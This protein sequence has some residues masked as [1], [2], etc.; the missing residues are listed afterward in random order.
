MTRGVA[1]RSEGSPRSRPGRVVLPTALLIMIIPC[2][3]ARAQVAGS[4][5]PTVN[6]PSGVVSTVP[7]ESGPRERVVAASVARAFF[8]QSLNCLGIAVRASA[9]V[10]DRALTL[11]CDKIR[12]MLKNIPRVRETLVRRGTELHIIGQHE[13]TSD[14]P[15]FRNQQD[16]VFVDNTGRLALIDERARGLGGHFPSCGE[17]NILRLPDDRYRGHEICIHEFAHA[18]MDYGMTA[19]ERK[20]I[21]DQYTESISIG[22]WDRAYAGTNPQEYWAELSVWYFGGHGDRRMNG[23]PPADGQVGLRVYDR[24]GFDLLDRLYNAAE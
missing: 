9:A 1:S 14:L 10:D 17:E 16:K 23:K 21:R 19:A 13:Q 20:Q 5:L 22:L 18:I 3:A 11:V 2:L 15:E 6:R 4:P 12:M 7:P 8:R 24:R